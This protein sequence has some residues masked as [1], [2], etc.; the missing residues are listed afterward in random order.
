MERGPKPIEG[1]YIEQDSLYNGFDNM[2]GYP[3][4]RY[5]MVKLPVGPRRGT[6]KSNK[7]R[8]P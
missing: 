7:E 3:I 6:R 1:Y 4:Q 5:T 2:T 8:E